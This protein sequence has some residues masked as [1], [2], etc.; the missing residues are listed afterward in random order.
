MSSHTILGSKPWVF[1]VILGRVWWL[2]EASEPPTS[3][4]FLGARV[5]TLAL[6][7]HPQQAAGLLGHGTRSK[8]ERC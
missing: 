6:A 1:P 3:G 2:C 4:L 7:R 5:A 8:S